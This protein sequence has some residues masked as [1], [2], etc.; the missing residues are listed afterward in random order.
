MLSCVTVHFIEAADVGSRAGARG[1]TAASARRSDRQPEQA[2]EH[3]GAAPGRAGH[4]GRLAAADHQA[5]A[6]ALQTQPQLL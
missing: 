5:H 2:T 4:H 6:P 1:V 3:R